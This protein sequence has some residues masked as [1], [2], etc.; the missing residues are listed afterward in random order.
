MCCNIVILW[1]IMYLVLSTVQCTLRKDNWNIA[2][3]FDVALSSMF[4]SWLKSR[5]ENNSPSVNYL[6]NVKILKCTWVRK[7]PGGENSQLS[8]MLLGDVCVRKRRWR[9]VVVVSGPL[10]TP[11]SVHWTYSRPG[12]S[13]PPRHSKPAGEIRPSFSS[14]NFGEMLQIRSSTTFSRFRTPGWAGLH[15][16]QCETVRAGQAS[17]PQPTGLFSEK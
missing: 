3:Q 17:Y 9:G 5:T 15:R 10:L 12:E 11:H 7:V 8:I 4:I 14:P 2:S 16:L 6:W 1:N 13:V